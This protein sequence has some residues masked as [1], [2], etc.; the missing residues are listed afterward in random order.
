MTAED[1]LEDSPR[2]DDAASRRAEA[3]G[4]KIAPGGQK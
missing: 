1:S 2:K 4:N 3:A